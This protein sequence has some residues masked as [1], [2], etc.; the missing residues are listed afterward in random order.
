MVSPENVYEHNDKKWTKTKH[1]L[2]V[3]TENVLPFL[4]GPGWHNYYFIIINILVIFDPPLQKSPKDC[5]IYV[6]RDLGGK[7]S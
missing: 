6:F 2:F 7:F 5:R 3:L 1:T 4:S